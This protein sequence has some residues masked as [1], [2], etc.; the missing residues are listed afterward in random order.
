MAT[1]QSNKREE[2]EED[3]MDDSEMMAEVIDGYKAA[4]KIGN[5]LFGTVTLSQARELYGF[6]DDDFDEET[7]ET[8]EDD[9]RS[10]QEELI[11]MNAGSVLFDDVVGLYV[12]VFLGDAD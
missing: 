8:F 4:K 1:K 11:N 5:K 9:L 12:D 3:E 2:E 10:C 7:L 6:L